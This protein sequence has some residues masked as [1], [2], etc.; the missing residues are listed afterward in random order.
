MRKFSCFIASLLLFIVSANAQSPGLYHKLS[1]PVGSTSPEKVMQALTAEYAELQAP[2]VTLSLTHYIESPGGHHFTFE[3][4]A[5]GLPVIDCG[6]KVLMDKNYRIMSVMNYLKPV[7]QMS[8]MAHSQSLAAAEDEVTRSESPGFTNY[9]QSVKPAWR[10]EGNELRPVFW[11]EVE[12]TGKWDRILLD[13]HSLAVVQR[14]N[15]IVNYAP[16]PPP[17]DTDGIGMVFHPDPLTPTCVN[18]GG[19]FVDNND[20][21]NA[22]LNAQRVQVTLHDISFDGTNYTLVGPHVETED[23]E[24]PFTNPPP[25][26]TSNDFSCTRQDDQFEWVMVYYHLDSMQRYVQ[27]LGFLNLYNEPIRVDAHGLN[28]ADN[29]HFASDANGRYL[30]FGDG[31]VDDAEDADVIIHEYGHALSYAGSP[32]TNSGNERQ[33][34]DEGIGDYFAASY[35]RRFDDCHWDDVFTWDGH[36]SCWPGR[37]ATTSMLYPPSNSNYYNYGEI[38]AST[39]M[40]FWG[41]EGYEVADKVQLQA[42]YTN[43]MNMN[44]NDAAWLAIDADSLLYGGVHTESLRFYFCLRGIFNGAEC[45][46]GVEDDQDVTVNWNVFP[47][48][49]NGEVNLEVKGSVTSVQFTVTDLSGRVLRSG[50]LQGNQGRID[51]SDCAAGSYLV[52]LTVNGASAGVKKL[53]IG[54]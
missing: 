30:A 2:G 12:A 15:H 47:N 39:M 22:T 6:I 34:L 4:Q 23:I 35:S 20:Q 26:L 37:D 31:C 52:S 13:G 46:V 19:N 7:G 42:L 29:S 14:D 5:A 45:A 16:P 33:G 8:R 18:Y 44:L 48:P 41:A 11:A 25:S 9:K 38:W 36:N 32:G 24:S 17:A 3:L 50:G 51:L 53:V 54:L 21:D 27:S 49:S 10:V 28:N 1:L 40:Q 43:S